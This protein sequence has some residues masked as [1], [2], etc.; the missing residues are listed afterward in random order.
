MI[1]VN[2]GHETVGSVVNQKDHLPRPIA[3]TEL[4]TCR[5][6]AGVKLD[7]SSGGRSRSGGGRGS[8]SSRGTGRGRRRR[9]IIGRAEAVAAAAE[10]L[11]GLLGRRLVFF[12]GALLYDKLQ[13][14]IVLDIEQRKWCT[15]SMDS[16]QQLLVPRLI[17]AVKLAIL[18]AET[19][20][21][22]DEATLR[23]LQLLVVLVIVVTERSGNA[24]RA[25]ATDSD[26]RRV[27]R[28]QSVASSAEGTRGRSR[29]FRL[30][31]GTA[32]MG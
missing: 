22:E 21:P 32:A 25:P 6:L 12:V 11:H 29:R 2:A 20:A 8:G 31:S 19:I 26:G 27:L 13:R 18:D 16:L 17:V 4:D 14:L 23:S 28:P 1:E 3:E 7:L 5:G 30:G 24:L 15:A 9:F 10:R